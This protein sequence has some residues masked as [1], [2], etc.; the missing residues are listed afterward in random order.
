MAQDAST[1]SACKLDGEPTESGFFA[2]LKKPFNVTTVAEVVAA[3]VN[4]RRTATG[5]ADGAAR[6]ETWRLT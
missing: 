2:A 4:H 1:S 5:L 6:E 3:A